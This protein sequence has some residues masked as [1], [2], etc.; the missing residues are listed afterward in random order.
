MIEKI[1]NIFESTKVDPV[2]WVIAFSGILMVRFFLEALSSP[3]SSGIIA[4][5]AP[6]LLHYYL[7]FISVALALM[8]LLQHALPTW[9]KVI[10]S[11]TLF[12]LIIILIPPII[13]WIVSGG[14]GFSMAYIFQSPFGLFLSLFTFFGTSFYSGITVGI[15]IE[16]VLMLIGVGWFIYHVSKSLKK[17]LFTVVALYLIMF[18]SVSLPS[19]FYTITWVFGDNSG[20]SVLFL[21]NSV[22]H[23]QSLV[24][25]IHGTLRYESFQRLFEIGFDFLMGRAWFIITTILALVWFLSNFKQKTLAILKNS[26]PER[27]GHYLFLVILGIFVAYHQTTFLLNWNDLLSLL[28]LL[29]AF[30]FSWMFAVCTND[31]YDLEI[32]QISNSDRPLLDGTMNVQDMKSAAFIF[33]ILSLVSAYLAGYYAFFCILAFTA[34]YYIYSVPPLRLKRIPFLSVFTIGFCSLSAILAGYFIFSSTK[35]VSAF[36]A[37][38]IAGI[39]I[40]FSLLPQIK[41]IKD[42]EGDKKAGIMTV[43]TL[44]GPIWGPRVIGGLAGLAYMIAPFVANNMFVFIGA[45]PAGV[46][47]YWIATK[48]PYTECPIF[49]VY[50]IF[51]IFLA[52]ILL[53]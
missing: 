47:T 44:F 45:L 3:S 29:L 50:G 4:S 51:V 39:V 2:Q 13:D 53:R 46:I 30:Y 37:G 17:T 52:V 20:N 33:L 40:M 19:I 8:L 36:P 31:I 26:R 14:K 38:L 32:D 25:N 18:V 24:N 7:F 11:M 1:K 49:I 35:I 22:T 5:D 43:P 10:P 42:I 9:K 28:T 12:A 48:K 23:S 41:D 27:I 34:L 15:R 6:T 21:Q 16:L